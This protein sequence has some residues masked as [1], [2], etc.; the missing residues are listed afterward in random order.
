VTGKPYFYQPSRSFCFPYF[1]VV[2][3]ELGQIEGFS[4]DLENPDLLEFSEMRID[5]D[6]F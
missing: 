2:L 6:E 1:R 5:P 3:V 4:I